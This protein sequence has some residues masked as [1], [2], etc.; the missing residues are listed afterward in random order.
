MTRPHSP[1]R[2]GHDKAAQAAVS[3]RVAMFTLGTAALACGLPL[4]ATAQ[5]PDAAAALV[6]RAVGD[7]LGIINSGR[8]ESAM[9]REFERIFRDYADVPIIAQSVVGPQWRGASDADRRAFIAAFQSYMARKYG[10]RFR[11]FIGGEI[12][13][14]GTRQVRNFVEVI[15]TVR[16]TGT[17]PFEVRWLVSDGSGQ[18]RFFN[19]IIEGV[20]LMITERSEI[21]AMLDARGGDL[22]RL[23]ADLRS[24]G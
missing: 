20:N 16:V 8:S 23:A 21:G 13:V 10:R 5:S 2:T 9:L 19:M 17:A 18:T 15:S 6:S 1:S 4:R 24:M 22:G 7:V 11:E 12:T 3:R 14:T